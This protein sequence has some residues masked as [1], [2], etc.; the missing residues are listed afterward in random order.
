MPTSTLTVETLQTLGV[1]VADLPSSVLRGEIATRL[2]PLLAS[3]G[4]DMKRDV[5]IVVLATGEGVVL[6]Q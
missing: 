2:E 4:F 5:R 3:R 1:S 6:T